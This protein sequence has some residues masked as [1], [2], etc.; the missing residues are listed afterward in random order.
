MVRELLPDLTGQRVADFSHDADPDVTR[1][2]RF[3]QP[4]GLPLE[5]QAGWA[6]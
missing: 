2:A 1:I 3:G 5:L 6:V 4:A